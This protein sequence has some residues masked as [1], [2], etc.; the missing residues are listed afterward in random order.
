MAIKKKVARRRKTATKKVA[1]KK[2]TP[3]ATPRKK[4][5]R[6]PTTSELLSEADA[7]MN[8]LSHYVGSINHTLAMMANRTD[9]SER[10]GFGEGMKALSGLIHDMELME[11]NLRDMISK[12]PTDRLENA[13]GRA[14]LLGLIW[15]KDGDMEALQV[16]KIIVGK[17][18]DVLKEWGM[19]KD[20]KTFEGGMDQTLAKS[21]YDALGGH[22]ILE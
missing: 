10:T 5:T 14:I 1:V 12:Q 13:L 4:T 16:H 11:N 18:M 20:V 17:V 6:K 7:K 22:N 9:E 21:I 8:V 2:A 19:K 15:Y 3:K